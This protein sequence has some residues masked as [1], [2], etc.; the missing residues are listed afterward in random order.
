VDKPLTVSEVAELIGVSEGLVY[1][2]VAAG[3]ITHL[4]LGAKGKRGAIRIERVDL[5]A[6]LAS[7]K[8]GEGQKPTAPMPIKLKHLKI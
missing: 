8:H 4:R 1:S 2:W 5:E 7:R 6:F 3:E